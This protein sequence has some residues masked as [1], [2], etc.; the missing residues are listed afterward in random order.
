V[1]RT[2]LFWSPNGNGAQSS[3]RD[4]LASGRVR[5]LPEGRLVKP[6]GLAT[7]LLVHNAARVWTTLMHRPDGDPTE[8]IYTPESP[9]SPPYPTKSPLWHFVSDYFLVF[10]SNFIPTCLFV[11]SHPI[12]GIFLV[13]LFQFIYFKLLE[14]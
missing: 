6:S 3:R 11:H 2:V 14:I 4:L 12:L 5:Q 1:V 7:C 8:A 13:F 10:W 9:L